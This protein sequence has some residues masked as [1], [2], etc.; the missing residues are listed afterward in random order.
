M[1]DDAN[2]SFRQTDMLDPARAQAMQAT[3]GYMPSLVAGNPLP[4]FF[5][6]LYFWTPLPPQM[7]GRDGHPARGQGV[8]PDMGLPRRMWAGGRLSFYEPLRLG[9]NAD[10]TTRLVSATRKEGKTGPLGIVGIRLDYQQ[11]GKLCLTEE[12]DLIYRNDPSPDAPT[13]VPPKAPVDAEEEVPL[14]F[15]STL[16]FRYSAL[17]FNGHRIHYDLDY[18][19]GV[20]GYDGLVVHGPLLAQHLMLLATAEFGRLKSFQ[21]RA[22]APLMHFE[23]ATAC[24]AGSKLWV[25]GP[26][27]RLCMEAE[28]AA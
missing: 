21:F 18:A 28:A 15:D 22:T 9:Q 2:P 25:R 5:H 27:G 11:K 6:Q 17:T 4:P 3:L 13:H 24:R 26:D 12:R 16:L 1:T 14:R 23:E 8:I 20:E 10:C 19:K 7:L